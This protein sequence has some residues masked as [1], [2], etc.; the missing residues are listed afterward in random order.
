[1][2]INEINSKIEKLNDIINKYSFFTGVSFEKT[3]DNSFK[4]VFYELDPSDLEQACT[5]DITIFNDTFLVSEMKPRVRDYYEFVQY[6]SVYRDLKTFMKI[7]RK[8]FV[9]YFKLSDK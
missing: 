3:G 6:L 9:E 2:K 5:I 4:I 1:M 8:S 7:A